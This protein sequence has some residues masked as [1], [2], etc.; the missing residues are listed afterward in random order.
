MAASSFALVE[1]RVN[2]IGE[3]VDARKVVDVIAKKSLIVVENLEC[4]E[5]TLNLNIVDGERLETI[6]AVAGAC[7]CSAEFR[8]NQFVVFYDN[9]DNPGP[10]SCG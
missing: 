5:G 6:I 8:G 7:G 9:P 3:D 2:I 1:D 10:P 4:I